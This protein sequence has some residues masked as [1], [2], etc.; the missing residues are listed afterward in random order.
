MVVVIVGV[1]MIGAEAVIDAVVA[2]SSSSITSYSI[3]L[4]RPDPILEK[5]HIYYINVT[6]SHVPWKPPLICFQTPDQLLPTVLLVPA[7]RSIRSYQSNLWVAIEYIFLELDYPIA[8][9]D[10]YVYMR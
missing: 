4:I 7:H 6:D 3:I 9:E 10:C 5:N 1:E 8:Q 2:S